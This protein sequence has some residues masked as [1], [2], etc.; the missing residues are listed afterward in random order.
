MTMTYFK[1]KKKNDNDLGVNM[2]SSMLRD[3][4]G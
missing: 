2:L 3:G 1:K 4:Y